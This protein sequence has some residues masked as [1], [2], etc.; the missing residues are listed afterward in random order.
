MKKLWAAFVAVILVAC[1]FTGCNRNSG[2]VN[3][4]TLGNNPV[5]TTAEP[6]VTTNHNGTS[7]TVVDHSGT[8]TSHVSSSSTEVSVTM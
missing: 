6:N 1:L 2:K 3:G 7:T 8:S 4:T 5:I